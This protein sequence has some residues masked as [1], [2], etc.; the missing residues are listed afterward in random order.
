MSSRFPIHVC[1]VS[2]QAT[3]NF[4]P[5]LDSRTRPEE[6]ILVVSPHMRKQAGWL[7]EAF[8]ARGIRVSEYPIGDPWDIAGIQESLLQLVLE[9]ADPRLALNVTG[10]TKP[11]AIAA[12]Q[13][14]DSEKL[15]IFYVHPE[16]NELLPCSAG[17]NTW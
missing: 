17:T 8:R 15:Q 12:Q 13:V 14:F 4:I 9:R 3:P 5:A 16:R 2:Q 11:M 10:G 1:L 6:V 7:G